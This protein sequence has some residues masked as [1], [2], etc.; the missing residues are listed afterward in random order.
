VPGRREQPV[1]H[2]IEAIEQLV[3]GVQGELGVQRDDVLDS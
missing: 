1:R 2:R 3:R